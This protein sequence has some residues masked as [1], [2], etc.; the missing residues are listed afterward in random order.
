MARIFLCIESSTNPQVSGSLTWERNFASTLRQMDQDV[1]LLSAEA[2]RI[3]MTENSESQR[4][5]FSRRI[6]ESFTEAHQQKPFDLAFFYLM[7]GM[8]DPACITDI[9]RLG[10]PT[11]NFSCNNIHQFYLVRDISRYFD[12]NLYAEKDAG[13][14]FESIEVNSLW[15]PMASNP[16][17]F[18]PIDV[19]NREPVATFVG[20]RYATRLDQ[21]HQFL[22]QGCPVKVYGPGWC[23]AGDE[24]LPEEMSRVQK[25]RMHLGAL[26][27]VALGTDEAPVVAEPAPQRRFHDWQEVLL[28]TS[29][30]RYPDAYH[31]PVSDRELIAMY[32]RSAVSLGFLEVFDQH[33][34]TL[35]RLKHL[36][37]RDFEAPMAGALYVT[38]YSDELTE[39]FEPGTEVLA[40]K[41][42]E[43]KIDWIQYYTAHP[44]AGEPI[45]LAARKRAVAD[46][47]YE[48]RF[49]Q[50]FDHLGVKL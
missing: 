46:H 3:A 36:H 14:K 22:E 49:R 12:L 35:A 10:V 42:L 4:A 6:V 25:T 16:D 38:D 26:R 21:I 7:D 13:Q 23:P 40:A 27:R 8:C 5:E 24:R 44:A 34:P 1:V 29:R 18:H 2:G 28:Q 19:A 33:D 50:L 17:V 31:P 43:E 11:C 47:S 41:T 20:G 15:W 9:S 32:S 45:R 37:L 30:D 39:M 48:Y